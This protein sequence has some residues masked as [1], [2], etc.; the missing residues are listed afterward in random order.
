MVDDGARPVHLSPTL[1]Q[2]LS[3]MAYVKRLAVQSFQ[4]VPENQ[5]NIVQGM[6]EL[7]RRGFPRSSLNTC[8]RPA[9]SGHCRLATLRATPL[10]RAGRCRGL[11]ALAAKPRFCPRDA[12]GSPRRIGSSGSS[13]AITHT[14]LPA[15]GSIR[16]FPFEYSSQ[17]SRCDHLA[18][19]A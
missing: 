6:V 13:R 18:A 11:V 14:S 4:C 10:L 16:S 12:Q 17:M 5:A 7:R 8:H 19:R 2:G 15:H 9:S 3:Y 1:L